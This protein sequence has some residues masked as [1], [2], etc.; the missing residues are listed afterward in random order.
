M[1]SVVSTAQPLPTARPARLFVGWGI[2]GD[3][4]LQVRTEGPERRN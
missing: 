3:A 4:V 2:G 1:A